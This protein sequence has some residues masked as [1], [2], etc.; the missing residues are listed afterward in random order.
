MCTYNVK[1]EDEV[2][3]MV[4]P[5]FDDDAALRAWIERQLEKV[6]REYAMQFI[7]SPAA[8]D[9]SEDIYQRV[10]ALEQDPR[11]LFKLGSILKPSKYSAEELRDEYISEKY[12]I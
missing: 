3:E 9:K 2:M 6:M 1:I 11:G 4:K 8:D 12:G 7:V 10:K 5:H